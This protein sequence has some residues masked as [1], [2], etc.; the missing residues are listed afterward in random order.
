MAALARAKNG[1]AALLYAYAA[2]NGGAC[3]LSE[4]AEWLGIDGERCARALSVLKL[5]GL[6]ADESMPPPKDSSRYH[7]QELVQVR[8]ED[9]AFNGLCNYMEAA[10]GR[11]MRKSELESLFGVYDVLNLSAD[12]LALLISYCKANLRLSVRELEKQAYLWHDLGIDNYEKAERYLDGQKLRLHRSRNILALFGIYGRLPGETEQKYIDGWERAGFSDELLKIAYDRTLTNTGKISWA[13]IDKI[14]R[15]WE[16]AGIK[17]AEQAQ[18]EEK[19]PP[20]QTAPAQTDTVEQTVM[21]LFE[22]RRRSRSLTMKKR[23]E[24]LAAA[25]P[26]FVEN[27]KRLRLCASRYARAPQGEKAEIEAEKRSL[28]ARRAEL[29]QK[30]GKPADWLEDK[31]ACAKC[32]DLGYIGSKMCDCFKKECEQEAAR[33]RDAAGRA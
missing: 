33:R 18:Q 31:P 11:M 28:T 15:R 24:E 26:E 6:A 1:D 17:T 27:E 25:S 32:G 14:L 21:K 13:Y 7:P 5:F 19:A 29:L 30:L 2:A 16:A 10:L 22:K 23:L 20:R 9:A 3:S 12:V 4:A 8:R